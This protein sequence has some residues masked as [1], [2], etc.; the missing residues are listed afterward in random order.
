[1]KGLFLAEFNPCA[2]DDNCS[3]NAIKAGPVSDVGDCNDDGLQTCSDS[4][5]AY[6][7]FPQKC[8]KWSAETTVNFRR[9]EN[10]MLRVYQPL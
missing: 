4:Y 1:M 8:G 10:C 5:A 2:M 7:A 9:V 6:N 3:A